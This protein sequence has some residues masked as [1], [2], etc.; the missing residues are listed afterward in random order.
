MKHTKLRIDE[1]VQASGEPT[2]IRD[3]YRKGG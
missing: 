3:L 1:P 2:I